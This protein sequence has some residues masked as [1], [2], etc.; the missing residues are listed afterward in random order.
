LLNNFANVREK[1]LVQQLLDKC[2]TSAQPSFAYFLYDESISDR[3]GLAHRQRTEFS[4]RP[5]QILGKYP[6]PV[7][8][9][10]LEDE[11]DGVHDLHSINRKDT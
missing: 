7:I 10:G 4:E 8:L 9:V 3:I 11:L 1:M 5:A 6:D 2:A